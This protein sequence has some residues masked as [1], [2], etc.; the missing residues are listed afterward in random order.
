MIKLSTTA[1]TEFAH[2]VTPPTHAIVTHASMIHE[3]WP[4]GINSLNVNYVY[5]NI[6]ATGAFA[7][8]PH[9]PPVV[10]NLPTH[11][12]PKNRTN[13]VTM[14]ANLLSAGTVPTPGNPTAPT[15]VPSK[16]AGQF[17]LADLDAIFASL[18]PALA[19][20]IV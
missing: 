13:E 19:G 5:G 15:A 6:D 10:V 9:C 11:F 3:P 14:L 2:L 20:A 12:D 4:G 7:P 1:T 8:N 17:A 18:H 16:K